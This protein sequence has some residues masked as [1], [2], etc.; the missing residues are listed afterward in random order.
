M[1]KLRVGVI[2]VGSVVR[3]IYQYL[4]FRSDYSH[5]LQIEAVADPNAEFRNWFGNTFGIPENRRFTGYQEMLEK[6]SFDAVQV[7]TPDHLHSQPAIAALE[8]GCDVVVPKPTAATVKET[9]AM[10]EAAKRTGRLLGIDF[11]KREDPRIKEVEARY[12]SG[13]Y[14]QLQ[15]TVWYMIDK[16]LVADPNHQ[17]PFF[18]TPNFAE[19]NTPV[20]F[21][22]VHMADALMKIVKL[23]PVE[24]RATGWSHKLPSLT[25]V[26][27]KGYDL[28][29]TEIRFENGAL[30]HVVTGWHLPNTAHALTVQS[31]RLICSGGM[32][33]MGIDQPG[34]HEIH[35][36]GIFEINPLFR[37]FEKDG[38]V[39]GYGISSPGRIYQRILAAHN[40]K[41]EAATRER[42][43]TPVELGFYTSLVLEAAELSLKQGQVTA[44]GV[45]TGSPIDLK[46]LLVREL[47]QSAATQYLG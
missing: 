44:P 2:G 37:N 5:L 19:R 20:S 43:M 29:D 40:G 13:R 30:A 14:G 26:A 36:D 27:V 38:M 9:H 1:D 16:L 18:A 31:S 45:T 35:P 22:T 17:P 10:I 39:T 28:C 46:A 32:I 6:V 41:L 21:L 4:Y 23:K 15:C 11:H 24:V 8:K 47:G 33:D 3:E 25:P 7:N 12:Q 34:V 42:M